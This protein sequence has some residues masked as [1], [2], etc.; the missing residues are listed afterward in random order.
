MC[1]FN[2]GRTTAQTFSRRPLIAE[3]WVRIQVS[4]YGIYGGQSGSGPI[5]I[6]FPLPLSFHRGSLY[7]YI[8]WGDE[9]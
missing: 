4:P 3:S 9:Q 6:V 8:I 7:P 1:L 2:Y 5:L